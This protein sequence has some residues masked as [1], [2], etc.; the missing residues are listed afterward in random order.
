MTTV[1]PRGSEHGN[2]YSLTGRE[3][4]TGVTRKLIDVTNPRPEDIDMRD[5]ARSLA[6]QERFTGH[7]PLRPTV[8]QHSLACLD[9]MSALLDTA[10]VL[11]GR[12]QQPLRAALMHDAAE[13]IVSDINCAV[14]QALRKRGT[15]AVS[16]F[17]ELELRAEAAIA[18][19]Y[20]CAVGEWGGL[21]HEADILACSYEMAWGG[22]CA[23]A[24]PPIW[25][26]DLGACYQSSDGG[27]LEFLAAAARLGMLS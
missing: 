4:L 1:A 18:A 3:I 20:G 25:L 7:C 9:V 21:V 15:L 17:D 6:H 26:D 11:S 10:N 27:E 19:A 2:R 5:I 12:W 23:D 8:A 24:R 22:W 16:S 13:Y 14:K